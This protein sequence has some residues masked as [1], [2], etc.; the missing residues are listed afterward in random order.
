MEYKTYKTVD[1]QI[2]YLK[3]NKKIIVDD[4][5]R[6]YLEERNYISLINPYKVF[7]ASGRNNEGRLI[8]KKQSNFKELL[9]IIKIDEDY[10]KRIYGLIGSFEKKFKNIIISE[11]CSKYVNINDS[12]CLKYIDELY[13][14][15]LGTIEFPMFCENYRYVHVKQSGKIIRIEDTYSIGRKRDVMLH[16]YKIATN[17][18]L[19]GTTLD[20]SDVCKNKLIVH[21][22]KKYQNVPLWVIPNALTL[23]E[24]QTIFSMLDLECQKNIISKMENIDYKQVTSEQ[25]ISF[26][27]HLELIRKMRNV[28]NHYEPILPFLLNEM[29]TK[30]I[31]DSK[32]YT[33]LELLHKTFS[34]F[35]LDNKE[36]II[37]KNPINSK[38][39]RILNMMHSDVG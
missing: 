30:K 3:D 36:I 15:L 13:K 39:I 31:E 23:G 20:D 32:I 8:Y 19:D 26:S 27:G 12:Y 2:Q 1:E 9:R 22:I 16:V 10:S 37:N 35:M 18:N 28:V 6:H 17:K 29:N 7:F 5:D 38:V 34:E 24:L 21:Y 11:I 33:T 25:I 14:F 4:E